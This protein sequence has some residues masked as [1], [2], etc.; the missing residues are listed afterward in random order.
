MYISIYVYLENFCGLGEEVVKVS[1][2]VA[3]LYNW[4]WRADERRER[5]G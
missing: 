4:Q 3:Y 2:R 5:R 1:E